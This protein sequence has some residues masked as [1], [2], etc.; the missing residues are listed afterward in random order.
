VVAPPCG[1]DLHNPA[2]PA[3]PHHHPAGVAR[4][5]LGRSSWNARAVLDD[6]LAGLIRVRHSDLE[7]GR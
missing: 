1:S 4:Q 2:V 6:G 5:A 7:V 3:V